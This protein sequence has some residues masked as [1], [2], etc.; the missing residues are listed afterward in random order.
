MAIDIY[1]NV[2]AAPYNAIG[3][4]ITDDTTALQSAINAAVASS[5]NQQRVEFPRGIYIVSSTLYLP[6]GTN[7]EGNGAV[8]KRMA[9]STTIFD[10]IVNSDPINGNTNISIKN[11]TIDGNRQANN[12]SPEVN[13]ERFSGLAFTK[14]SDSFLENVTANNTVNGEIQPTGSTC[15]GIY[16]FE[17]NDIICNRINGFDNDRSAILLQDSNR[18][19]IYGSITGG[20]SGSGITSSYSHECEYHDLLSYNNGTNEYSVKYSNISINGLKCK[21]SN[22]TTYG[23][24]GSGLN[25]GHYHSNEEEQRDKAD[26]TFISRVHSYDNGIEGVT[27]AGSYGVILTQIYVENNYR[28]NI[29]IYDYASQTVISHIFSISSGGTGILYESG[30]GHT[31][32]NATVFYSEGSGI[33]IGEDTNVTVGLGVETFDNCKSAA[34][35]GAGVLV[36]KAFDCRIVGLKSYDTGSSSKKQYGLWIAGTGSASRENQVLFDWGIKN[37]LSGINIKQTSVINLQRD[38]P[39]LHDGYSFIAFSGTLP[40]G[41]TVSSGAGFWIDSNGFVHLVG[42]FNNGTVATPCFQLPSA[43]RPEI[44]MQFASSANNAHAN[45]VIDTSGNIILY[46]SNVNHYVDGIAF[47]AK[48]I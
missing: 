3:D 20:N 14:V 48:V 43:Y 4:G 16:L 1:I 25:I 27:I 7:I 44:G 39:I 40:N 5:T 38:N 2:T 26:Y 21:G 13:A 23:A 11:L 42:V 36:D 32:S 12:L 41:W 34:G 37:N 19:R 9:G 6:T 17:C 18:I 30:V 31:I 24:T 15:A 8:I 47:K 35:S 29:K 10:M 33:Y 28:N 22:I 45:T 46:T